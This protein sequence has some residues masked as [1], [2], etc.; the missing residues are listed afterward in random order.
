MPPAGLGQCP[1]RILGMIPQDRTVSKCDRL[2]VDIGFSLLNLGIFYIFLNKMMW[3]FPEVLNLNW[4]ILK[5]N[6]FI[7]NDIVLSN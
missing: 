4:W 3:K 7:Y 1:E 6:Q 2:H 5:L